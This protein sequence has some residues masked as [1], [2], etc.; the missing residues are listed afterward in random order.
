MA[1]FQLWNFPAI[2]ARCGKRNGIR[3]GL[4]ASHVNSHWLVNPRRIV[5]EKTQWK[6]TRGIWHDSRG[7]RFHWKK[8][9]IAGAVGRE[10]Y[11]FTIT[12]NANAFYLRK[13]TESGRV[14]ATHVLVEKRYGIRERLAASHVNLQSRRSHVEAE[15]HFTWENSRTGLAG[16]TYKFRVKMKP[17][18]FYT[19]KQK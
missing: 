10:S 15:A 4:A 9:R 11:K 5:P 8:Q 12:L 2:P 18:A 19:R 1:F 6:W 3:Q 16:V 7:A 14:S 13:H 17:G